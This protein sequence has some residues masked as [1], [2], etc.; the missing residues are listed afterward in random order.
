MSGTIETT[1]NK[2]MD[3]IEHTKGVYMLVRGLLE[4]LGHFPLREGEN[5]SASALKKGLASGD[6]QKMRLGN[7]KL[8]LAID[9]LETLGDKYNLTVVHI[10]GDYYNNPKVED[11]V[12][13]EYYQTVTSENY[14][15]R[16]ADYVTRAK[17]LVSGIIGSIDKLCGDKMDMAITATESKPKR[18]GR[19]PKK[20]DSAM[21]KLQLGELRDSIEK[22]KRAIS[23]TEAIEITVELNKENYEV[24]RCGERMTIVPERS[25]LVCESCR[26]IRTL[27]GLVFD[28]YQFYTQGEPKTKHGVYNPNRHFK[29]WMERIQARENKIFPPEHLEKIDY[30]I[31][32]DGIPKCELNCYIMRSILKEAQLTQYNDHTSLLIKLCGGPTP[33]QL[34]YQELR[35]FSIKFNKFMVYLKMVKKD[36][37]RPNYPYWIYKIA[38]DEFE[39]KPD[40]VRILLFIHL[41]SEDTIKKNDAY[42]EAICVIADPK[43]NLT[44]RP[45][46][47]PIY[48]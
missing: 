8:N 26:K 4:E 3:K 14:P 1:H 19:P 38:E 2:I 5:S 43:D 12:V 22:I 20:Q 13:Y 46:V 6:Q 29:F 41:Q 47:K 15:A 39:D 28:D 24:C 27:Y 45:T 11:K 18:R 32:R 35:V 42:L 44:F 40:K 7:M 25:E 17:Q 16:I 37:N 9:E 21:A 23:S 30:I 36:G 33:P 31:R 48:L 10:L 34:E